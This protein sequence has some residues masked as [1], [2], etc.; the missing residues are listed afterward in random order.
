MAK[1]LV[2]DDDDVVTCFLRLVLEGDGHQVTVARDGQEAL[3][4]VA[5][6]MP[7]LILL[8]LEMPR[9]G[10]FDVLH[11]LKQ[12][13]ATRLLPILIL[14][15]TDPAEFR[16]SAW[17]LGADEFLS[18]PPRPQELLARCRALLRV[19]RLVDELDSAEAVVFAFARAVDAK[20]VYTQ[21]HS[22]RV[23][24]YSVAL[25]EKLGLSVDDVETLRRG[26]LLHDLGKIS[27][28]DAILNKPGP[29]TEEE[30]NL[31]K[32]H[33]DVGFRILERLRSVRNL[34]PLVKSH[35]E[36]LDGKGYPD[37]LSAGSIPK[38][39]RIL[40]VAD[41]YDALSSVRPYR[42]AMPQ[43]RCFEILRAEAEDGSLDPD[44]VRPFCEL[45]AKS[46]PSAPSVATLLRIPG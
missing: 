12:A 28:P 14:T 24:R 16:A 39:V 32:Q 3:D 31:V 46:T 6:A 40:S 35:H 11:R 18:K 41:V 23:S 17:A 45:M 25:G 10:G 33:P 2:V 36:R 29:L 43:A 26:A 44:L 42:P 15:G 38:L 21:E 19:K 7:D 1:I 22:E 30:Y 4:L 34:L 5:Q 13:P 37:G 9:I 20:C 27:L 8:D